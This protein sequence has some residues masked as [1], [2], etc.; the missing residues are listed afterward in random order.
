MQPK[1]MS[2]LFLFGIGGTGARVIKSLVMLMAAGVDVKASKIVP[3]LIDPDARNGDTVRTLNLLKLY[4]SLQGQ[5]G[6]REKGFF[7]T[8]IA[9]LQDVWDD[10]DGRLSSGFNFPFL[11]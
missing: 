9:T 10:K 6:N 3:I 1:T 2:K 8:D 5:L 7:K 11:A 4:K